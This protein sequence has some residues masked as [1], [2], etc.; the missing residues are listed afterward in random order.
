MGGKAG[1][2]VLTINIRVIVLKVWPCRSVEKQCVPAECPEIGQWGTHLQKLLTEVL[3]LINLHTSIH[4]VSRKDRWT[5][6]AHL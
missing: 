1:Q 4:Y 2:R 5:P 6:H 3:V